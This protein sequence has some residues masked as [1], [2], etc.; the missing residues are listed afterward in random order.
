MM[1]LLCLQDLQ[2]CVILISPGKK[3]TISMNR[4]LLQKKLN[5]NLGLDY[6]WNLCMFASWDYAIVLSCIFPITW[7]GWG[8]ERETEKGQEQRV[9]TKPVHEA[10]RGKSGRRESEAT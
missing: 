8:N 4:K 10:K 9:K 1:C 3:C 2:E 5:P 7:R 6:I